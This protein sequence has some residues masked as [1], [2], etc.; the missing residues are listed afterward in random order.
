MDSVVV[1]GRRREGMEVELR[2]ECLISDSCD[3]LRRL[4]E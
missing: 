4:A 3:F 2:S 1:G